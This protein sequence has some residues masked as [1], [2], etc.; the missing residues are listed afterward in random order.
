VIS[1]LLREGF[2]GNRRFPLEEVK[3]KVKV[4]GVVEGS[5]RVKVEEEEKV[6]IF[7][8]IFPV[9]KADENMGVRRKKII[10]FIASTEFTANMAKEFKIIVRFNLTH[11]ITEKFGNSSILLKLIGR[12][13]HLSGNP[14]IN[15]LTS[16]RLMSTSTSSILNHFLSL[17]II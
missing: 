1:L 7:G 3:V 13:G 2:K 8:R 4:K 5:R 15:Q 11:A 9:T 16:L 17:R 6:T 10:F 14:R 12:L